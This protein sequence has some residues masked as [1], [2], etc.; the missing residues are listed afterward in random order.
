MLRDMASTLNSRGAPELRK[1]AF[2]KQ[3]TLNFVGPKKFRKP[4][5]KKKLYFV[6]SLGPKNRKTLNF[7][8]PKKFKKFSV[9]HFFHV[10]RCPKSSKS[11]VFCAFFLREKVVPVMA[12]NFDSFFLGWYPSPKE[13]PVM[14]WNLDTF[15]F[16]G[17]P[18]PPQKKCA[19]YGM[20]S[21]PPTA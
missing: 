12:L 21:L 6:K 3:T 20:E 14:A 7:L 5:V 8:G 4:M 16:G 11:S 1:L 18:S 10:F 19:S 2:L 9:F 13:V 15:L 17:C